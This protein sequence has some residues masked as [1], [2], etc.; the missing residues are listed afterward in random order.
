MNVSYFVRSKRPVKIAE[1]VSHCWVIVSCVYLLMI[2]MGLVLVIPQ[3]PP[4]QI[5][6]TKLTVRNFV[7]SLIFRNW[8][9][10]LLY[11]TSHPRS[12]LF[13]PILYVVEDEQN[14]VRLLWIV[15]GQVSVLCK[16]TRTYG[17]DSV[18]SVR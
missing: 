18:L 3:L 9:A 15:E 2:P 10:T 14:M 5:F 4:V 7:A 11:T 13:S 8:K 17:S 6:T 12:V 16:D 1:S